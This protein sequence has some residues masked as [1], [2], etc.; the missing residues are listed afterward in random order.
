[1]DADKF[2]EVDRDWEDKKKIHTVI[3]ISSAV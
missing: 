2:R 3:Q 1:M